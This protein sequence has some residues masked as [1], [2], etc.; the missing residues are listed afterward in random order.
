[1]KKILVGLMFLSGLPCT[2][3]E[4]WTLDTCIAYATEN[5]I[6]V[7]TQQYENEKIQEDITIAKGDFFPDA[8]FTGSQNYRLGSSLDI[9]TGI[10]QQESRSNSF[11]LSSS[12]TLFNG[13]RKHYRL[14]QSKLSKEKGQADIDRIIQEMTLSITDRYLEVLFN[15]EILAV[16]KEQEAISEQEVKR[17]QKLYDRGFVSKRDLLEIQSTNAFDTKEVVLAENNVA[18]SLIQ[19]KEILAIEDIENFDIAPV[20]DLDVDA[21]FLET[22]GKLYED[23]MQNNPL[24][25]ATSLQT[26]IGEKEVKIAQSALY[27]QVNFSYSFSSFYFHIQGQEDVIFNQ[28]TQMFED[29]GFF[30]QL[31]NNKIHFIG[32]NATIPI[33][34]R[35]LNKSTI[36]KIKIDLTIIEQTLENQK[37]ELK[38]RITI[39]SNDIKSAQASKVASEEG[40]NA[41]KEAFEIVVRNYQKGNLSSYDFLESKSKYA[42]AQ[43]EAIRS[44]YEYI[45]KQKYLSFLLG[46]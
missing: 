33:F 46:K 43:S 4:V 14:Q 37:K 40:L 23:A 26:Q 3:Q 31:N 22:S 34:N 19:L 21:N 30:T 8:N 45:L 18:N 25:R 13:F 12:L 1:M 27:P 28:Q 11:S 9:S 5:N 20:Q 39:A 6:D 10:G 41:Q 16:A 2:A 38:N 32:L 17:L 29:N 44:K 24:I 15:K 36:D 35:F 7:I 42:Q